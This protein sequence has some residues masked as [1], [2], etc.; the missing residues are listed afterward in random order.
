MQLIVWKDE[1]ELDYEDETGRD[2]LTTISREVA[3]RAAQ[4]HEEA[5]Y[6]VAQLFVRWEES[7]KHWE[8]KEAQEQAEMMA[9][10]EEL[11][12]GGEEEDEEAGTITDPR[13]IPAKSG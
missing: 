9:T 8:E 4:G 13:Y 2:T 5:R 11:Y 10:M 6:R 12:L 7:R 1:A 3:E